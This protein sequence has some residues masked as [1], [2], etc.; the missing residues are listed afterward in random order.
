MEN[1]ELILSAKWINVG[2][3]SHPWTHATK[4][5]QNCEKSNA[6]AQDWTRA[7]V[8]ATQEQF[9]E[10]TTNFIHYLILLCTLH[11]RSLFLLYTQYRAVVYIR[12]NICNIP[13]RFR[14]RIWILYYQPTGL[15]RVTVS[16][17][18]TCNK[19]LRY[20]EKTNA[21]AQDWTRAPVRATQEQ[22]HE[23]MTSL[24]PY[25]IL[26]CFVFLLSVLCCMCSGVRQS[27]DI[28]PFGW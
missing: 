9:H 28:D 16:P 15:M 7:P 11:C 13:E 21:I 2:W 18:N 10:A 22:F 27:P 8:R 24:I 17:W 25:L 6:I 12:R 1:M 20:C 14:W 5:T 19:A 3:L 26:L 4:H 23:A